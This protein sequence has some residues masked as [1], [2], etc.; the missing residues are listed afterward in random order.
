MVD[1]ALGRRRTPAILREDLADAW[2]QRGPWEHAGPANH[3][4]ADCSH[5]VAN[6]R[7]P[8]PQDD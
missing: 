4:A 1:S 3:S 8:D 7:Q 6:Q 2:G 5:D